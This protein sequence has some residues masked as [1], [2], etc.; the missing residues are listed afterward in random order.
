[1]KQFLSVF[2]LS[3]LLVGAP[4]IAHEDHG[5][6]MHGGVFAEAGHAQFE[7]VSRDGVL[8]VHVSNHGSPVATAGATGKLTVLSGSAKRDIELKPA[9]VDLLQGQGTLNSGDKLLL[10]VSWPD[11]KPI[12]ARAVVK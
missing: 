8:T 12:Q 4:A 5:K 6:T 9:G 11:Q 10:S 1:M 3:A 2:A 7:I